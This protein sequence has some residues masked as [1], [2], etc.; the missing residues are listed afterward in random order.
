MDPFDPVRTEESGRS[1]RR[2]SILKVPRKSIV[3]TEIVQQDKVVE[4]ANPSDKRISRRVSFAPANDVHLFAKD[5]KNTSPTQG[6]LE[7]LMPGGV[8]QNRVP[9]KFEDQQFTGMDIFLNTPKQ[10][11]QPND[12]ARSNFEEKTIMFNADDL[13]MTQCHTITITKDKDLLDTSHSFHH[14][15]GEKTMLFDRSMDMTLSQTLNIACDQDVSF[16]SKPTPNSVFPF[17]SAMTHGA[18]F[19][20]YANV[21]KENLVPKLN[22]SITKKMRDSY[23]GL[24]GAEDDLGVT[25][26]NPLQCLFPPEIYAEPDR[27]K[28]QTT[29]KDNSAYEPIGFASKQTINSDTND[30]C[31]SDKTVVFSDDGFMDITQ[32]WTSNIVVAPSLSTQDKSLKERK[33]IT[34]CLSTRLLDEQERAQHH[35]TKL[36]R[37]SSCKG[38]EASLK[39]TV[40]QIKTDSEEVSREK[41]VRFSTDDACI[42][43]TRCHT[44]KISELKLLPDQGNLSMNGEKTIRFNTDEAGMDITQPLTVNIARDL[45]PGSSV[46]QKQASS[47]ACLPEQSVDLDFQNFFAS[48][49]GQTK[50]NTSQGN[51]NKPFIETQ[52]NTQTRLLINDSK[53]I[54]ALNEGA[55]ESNVKMD[56]SQAHTSLITDEEKSYCS[57]A[58]ADRT[59]QQQRNVIGAYLN[60]GLKSFQRPENQKHLVDF[61]AEER[62]RER[63]VWFAAEDALMDVTRSHTVHI[64]RDLQPDLPLS[65]KTLR[66]DAEMD[67]TQCHTVNIINEHDSLHK[68]LSLLPK[69]GEKTVNFNADN[70]AMDMTSSQTGLISTDLKP[71]LPLSEKTLRFDA[72]MDTTQCHTVNIVNNFN[73][74]LQEFSLVPNAAERSSPF[75][76]NSTTKN[77]PKSDDDYKVQLQRNVSGEKTLRF[78]TDDAN[79]DVTKSHTMIIDIEPQVIPD[80]AIL[81]SREDKTVQFSSDDGGM[82]VTQCLTSSIAFEMEATQTESSPAPA[83]ITMDCPALKKKE[84]TIYINRRCRSLA[85][86]SLSSALKTRRSVPWDNRTVTSTFATVNDNMTAAQSQVESKEDLKYKQGFFAT[87]KTGVVN[88]NIG[89]LSVIEEKSI[90]EISQKEECEENRTINMTVGLPVQLSKQT[91]ADDHHQRLV[92]TETTLSVEEGNNE[93]PISKC[94]IQPNSP[95]TNNQTDD[96]ERRQEEKT[97]CLPAS[98]EKEND[99]CHP[100]KSRR[101]SLAD[102]QSKMRRISQMLSAPPDSDAVED[103]VPAPDSELKVEVHKIISVPEHQPNA[104]VNEDKFDDAQEEPLCAPATPYRLETERLM[105]Q[106]S[107]VGCKPK[108]PRRSKSEEAKTPGLVHAAGKSIKMINVQ[109]QNQ[110]DNIDLN[111]SDINDEE[112][113]S[114]EDV[115]ETLDTNGTDKELKMTS[116][117]EFELDRELQDEVFEDDPVLVNERKRPLPE[118][119]HFIDNEKRMKT[120]NETIISDSQTCTVDGDGVLGA[121]TL[122][123]DSSNCSQMASLRSEATFESTSKQSLFESQL[124]DYASDIQRKFDDGTLTMAEFFK[125]FHIDFVIHNPRQSVVPGTAVSDKEPTLMDLSHNRH[126]SLPKQLVYEANVQKLTEQVEGLKVRMRDLDKPLVQVNRTLREEMEQFSEAEFKSFGAKIKERHNLYRKISKAQSHEMKVGLY[127]ELIQ[128]N[129]E[130]QKKLKGSIEKADDMLKSLDDCIGQLEGEL[131]TVE[132]S[133]KSQQED[134]NKVTDEIAHNEKSMLEMEIQKKQNINKLKRVKREVRNLET[135]LDMLHMLKEWNLVEHQSNRAVYTFLH[136]TLHLVLIYEDSKENEEEKKITDISFQHLL[137]ERS[138]CHARLVH[139]L[140]SQFTQENNW[141]EKYSTS[142]HVPLLLHDVSLVVTRCRQFG[143]ELRQLKTWGSLRFDILDIHCLHSEV[144]IV[145]SSLKKFVKFEIVLSVSLIDKLCAVKLQTFKNIIGNT[146]IE[147]VEELVTSSTPGQN[148]LTKM[149]QNIHSSLLC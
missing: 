93:E 126:I 38:L 7:E 54:Q 77:E 11:F 138:Q 29:A 53:R 21:D 127:S 89:F 59:S 107:V 143:E 114:Y 9:K 34:N 97:E 115:S 5:V 98:M 71:D 94:D 95:Q 120:G 144:Y 10:I 40:H 2:T 88:E 61:D 84:P 58:Q 91:V 24:V 67:T 50:V 121:S 3:S 64:S 132:G 35:D 15:H 25:E 129:E 26:A 137:D 113:E 87:S 65:D 13:D 27:R 73:L 60:K 74:S 44:V 8:Q 124:E 111:V 141:T 33:S 63:T 20:P 18:E 31:R 103:N 49:S 78:N 149:I 47:V 139:T 90:A 142:K 118:E 122:S 119:E 92:V 76:A 4:C 125:L 117:N 148:Y 108:L 85:G 99:A 72:E 39:T 56:F 140:V 37:V 83:N 55:D 17:T 134:L 48:L 135:H 43:V 32:N 104:N 46:F 81:P 80:L 6:L 30:N 79:M 41:T 19:L 23:V 62:H 116:F 110:M 22:K 130:E 112:L 96:D 36:Q 14:R 123:A 100:Q 52:S 146:T 101:R 69:Y 57:E 105:S 86:N 145:F 133:I 106:L 102:I 45:V 131:A 42:E 51:P 66:F 70:A 12:K 82:E 75:D 1:K 147:H 16:S 28:S 109:V 128:A 136:E 68:Y